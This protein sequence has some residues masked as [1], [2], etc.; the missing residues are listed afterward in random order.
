MITLNL[1]SFSQDLFLQETTEEWQQFE[2]KIESVKQWMV[3]TRNYLNSPDMKSKPLRDQL[4]AH[5]QMLADIAAQKIKV[6]MSL[7]KLQVK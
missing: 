1:T 6:N 2:K 3:D 7:E 5:E 4:R